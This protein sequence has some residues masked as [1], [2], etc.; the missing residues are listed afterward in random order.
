MLAQ[1]SA[2]TRLNHVVALNGYFEIRRIKRKHSVR[3]GKLGKYPLTAPLMVVFGTAVKVN[4]TLQRAMS[5]CF[6]CL[7]G[8]F[9]N[10]LTIYLRLPTIHLCQSQFVTESGEVALTSLLQLP[11]HF[12]LRLNSIRPNRAPIEKCN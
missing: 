3:V 11:L 7:R 9:R 1:L 12:V 8:V 10:S 6:T 2:I 4:P 5:Q